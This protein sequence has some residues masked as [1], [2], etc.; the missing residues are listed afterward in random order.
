MLQKAMKLALEW[1]RDQDRKYMIQGLHVPYIVHPMAVMKMVWTWGAGT[2]SIMC[3]AVCH[4][5]IEDTFMTYEFLRAIIGDQ[6]ADIV[7]ELTLEEYSD[8]E[9]YLKSFSDSSIEALIIKIADR[10]DNVKDYMSNRPHYAKE[11][12]DKAKDLFEALTSRVIEIQDKFGEAVYK[13]I[14]DSYLAVKISL[15]MSDIN[16]KE[17]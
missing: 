7:K 4:D 5:L 3:A 9:K 11:Y 8:K 16:E 6:A 12:F 1:H 15:S 17:N 2:E 13:N 14:I 10:L